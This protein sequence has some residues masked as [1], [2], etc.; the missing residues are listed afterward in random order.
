MKTPPHNPQAHQ[1][2]RG[3]PSPLQIA[4]PPAHPQITH[5]ER[6]DQAH[7]PRLSADLAHEDA[8][9]DETCDPEVDAQDADDDEERE[10][11]GLGFSFVLVGAGVRVSVARRERRRRV[12]AV[13]GVD[14]D[15]D[16]QPGECHCTERDERRAPG[17]GLRGVEAH[18][19][20]M[21]QLSIC[22]E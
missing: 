1:H 4:Q 3:A 2:I 13:V 12:A 18:R 14:N 16:E 15:L 17:L 7:V 5:R 19:F 22:D 20:S 21:M 9:G 11:V 6:N 10:H 8:P